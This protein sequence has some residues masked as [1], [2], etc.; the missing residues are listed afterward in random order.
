MVFPLKRDGPCLDAS[1]NLAFDVAVQRGC[2]EYGHKI[3]RKFSGG[4][5]DKK[6][7]ST[8]LDAYISQLNGI[9]VNE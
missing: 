5:L 1:K 7:V 8:V 6:V 3:V 2:L 4:D 9:I